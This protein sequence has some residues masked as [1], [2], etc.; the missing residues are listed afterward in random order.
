MNTLRNRLHLAALVALLVACLACTK[1]AQ[2]TIPGSLN[3]FD[4]T[5]YKTLLT[6]QTSIEEAKTQ[7]GTHP[8]IKGPL[9]AVIAAYNAAQDAYKLYHE[10][11]ASGANPG[12]SALSD[13]IAALVS[14]VAAITA[15]V[16]K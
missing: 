6:V 1:N 13:Q 3:D 11:A 2:V 14:D 12:T 4:A 8:Q 16:A 7:L 5:A 9:N 10:Q 15:Q